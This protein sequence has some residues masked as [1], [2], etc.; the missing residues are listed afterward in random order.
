MN[1]NEQPPLSDGRKRVIADAFKKLDK[2]GDGVV[3][4]DDL[5]N[6]YNVKHNPRYLSGEETEEQIL[7]KFLSV[8]EANGVI[9]GKV[10]NFGSGFL[11]SI[12][13]GSNLGYGGP[14]IQTLK[15]ANGHQT[16]SSCNETGQGLGKLNRFQQLSEGQVP[17][18]R[19]FDYLFDCLGQRDVIHWNFLK[20]TMSRC[21][22]VDPRGRVSF[23]WSIPCQ[24]FVDENSIHLIYSFPFLFLN[25]RWRTM[26]FWIITPVLVR[27]SITTPTLIWW[28]ARPGKFKLISPKIPRNFWLEFPQFFAA[29]QCFHSE[30]SPIFLSESFNWKTTACLPDVCILA[31]T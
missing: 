5:R 20:G 15:I 8:F 13:P 11:V 23:V 25:N 17:E 19:I 28:C 24:K 4:L 30:K 16:H 21:R 27:P 3:T 14:S 7:K 2:T 18:R 6:V 31:P 12:Q 22:S 9:D 29:F 26:N 1:F 10:A